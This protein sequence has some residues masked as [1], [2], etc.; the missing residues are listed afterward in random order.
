MNSSAAVFSRTLH[1]LNTLFPCSKE[2]N[3]LFDKIRKN[4]KNG[5]YYLKE[6][7]KTM[8]SQLEIKIVN[9]EHTLKLELSS[10]EKECFMESKSFSVTPTDTI[11]NERYQTLKKHL[12]YIKNIK[13]RCCNL[14]IIHVS[15]TSCSSSSYQPSI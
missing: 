3:T 5:Q 7:Y 11:K 14:T 9:L 6:D 10:I 8:C 13:N 15:E 4:I 2:F 12:T 1:F